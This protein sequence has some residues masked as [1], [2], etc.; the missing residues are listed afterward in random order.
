V[1]VSREELAQ[2]FESLSEEELSQHLRS[3]TLTA[4]AV[5]VAGDILR[6]RGVDPETFPDTADSAVDAIDEQDLDLVTVSV[7]WNP[8]KANV[9][10]A[11]LE[12]HGI[13]AYVWGEHLA[14]AHI[15]LSN[16]G[17]GSRVQ[18]RSDQVSQARELI[19][20]FER[21]ELQSPDLP[22]EET[23]TGQTQT[24]PSRPYSFP[25]DPYVPSPAVIDARAAERPAAHPPRAHPRADKSARAPSGPLRKISFLIAGSAIVLALWLM[26]T[27]QG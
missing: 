4:L 25:S 22:D 11:L 12:S 24:T 6:L 27:H 16:A 1:E 3:G 7:Q 2:H 8:L 26:F 21:G 15:L 20:A 14:T 18:V 10:R 23:A 17:G 13:F 9:L 5:E 19:G